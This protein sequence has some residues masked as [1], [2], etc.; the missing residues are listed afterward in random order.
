MKTKIPKIQSSITLITFFLSGILPASA[1]SLVWDKPA[2]TYQAQAGETNA[3]FVFSVTNVS[4]TNV[5]IRSVRTSCGCTMAKLPTL[6][7]ELTPGTNGQMEVK[8]D[9]RGKRGTLSKVISVDASS[10]L[11]L[12]SVNVNIPEPDP[13]ERNRM[14]A[15]ADRQAIFRGECASCH[16]QPAVGKMGKEL[17]AAACAICHEAEHRASMVPDLKVLAKP[18]DR[19][20]WT[21]W[22]TLG[23]IGTLMPGF[24]KA[25]GGPLDREQILSLVDYLDHEYRPRLVLDLGNPFPDQP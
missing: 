15:L 25:Q 1:D 19:T 9:L 13:R 21:S 12:L 5:L 24:A 14:M 7:W 8:V 2:K 23:K 11:Q 4:S 17:F 16:V 6:P 3:F 22:V 10:G 18:T 20:Y